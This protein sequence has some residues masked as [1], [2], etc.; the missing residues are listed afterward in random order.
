MRGLHLLEM[1]YIWLSPALIF[2]SLILYFSTRRRIP[3]SGS[4]KPGDAWVLL[5]LELLIFASVG[6]VIAFIKDAHEVADYISFAAPCVAGIVV[7]LGL[8]RRA[9]KL[10]VDDPNF[11]WDYRSYAVSIIIL[12]ASLIAYLGAHYDALVIGW[13]MACAFLLDISAFVYVFSIRESPRWSVMGKVPQVIMMAVLLVLSGAFAVFVYVN[14]SALR[15]EL[16]GA[17]KCNCNS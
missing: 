12:F 8:V 15:G 7:G 11:Y 9:A 16:H 2:V 14:S 6:M 4:W 17:V 3:K 10:V 1:L 13:S 5:I